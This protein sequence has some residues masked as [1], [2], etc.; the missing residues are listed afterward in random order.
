[1]YLWNKKTGSAG[2]A[3]NLDYAGSGSYREDFGLKKV[4]V[5]PIATFFLQQSFLKIFQ[6]VQ[7]E[8]SNLKKYMNL[9][10]VFY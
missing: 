10:Y 5:Y 2:V 4:G 3:A 1:M 6:S 8:P 7:P 9:F